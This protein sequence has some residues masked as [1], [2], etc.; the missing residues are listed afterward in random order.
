MSTESRYGQ[1]IRLDRARG[2]SEILRRV[3]LASRVGEG[4]VDETGLQELIFE[5]PECLPIAAID[6]AYGDPVPVCRE[7]RIGDAGTIDAVYINRLGRLS[8]CEFKL[9]RN[10]EARRKVI[11]QILDYAT[12]IAS[13]GYEDLQRQV[14]LAPG[15]KKGNSLYKLVR[16]RHPDLAEAEFV[17]NVTR[18]LRRG[19]FLLLIVGD[20]IRERV[21]RIVDFVQ[22]HSGLH[23]NLALVEAALYRDG[24]DRLLVQPRVLARTEIVRR[25]VVDAGVVE[26]GT[27]AAVDEPGPLSDQEEENRRFWTAVLCDYTFAD[28][29]VEPPAPRHLPTIHVL[30]TNS[31]FGGWALSFTAYINRNDGSIGCFVMCRKGHPREQRI[32]DETLESLQEWREPLGGDVKKWEQGGRPRFGY[33]R[34]DLSFLSASEDSEEYQEAVDWIRQQLDRLVSALHHHFQERLASD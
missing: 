13:W 21:E 27:S 8:L 30:V 16:A 20:G 29:A 19:E 3:P 32:F 4:G 11:G 22:R 26:E 34:E 25:F 6:A 9:W 14:A 33:W 2:S 23:F 24:P 1:L 18:H 17:D 12:N 31:G 15:A 7:L 5:Y 10:P 28:E